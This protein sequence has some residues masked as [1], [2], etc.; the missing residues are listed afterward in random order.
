MTSFTPAL[1]SERSTSETLE[2]FADLRERPRELM[3]S[4]LTVLEEPAETPICLLEFADTLTA[5]I[6]EAIS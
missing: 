3:M 2:T 6:S 4:N 1:L 5:G